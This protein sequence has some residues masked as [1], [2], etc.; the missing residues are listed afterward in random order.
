M[1]RIIYDFNTKN[2]L[3]S[4]NINAYKISSISGDDLYLQVSSNNNIKIEGNIIPTI[5]EN[6]DLG[7]SNNKIRYIYVNEVNGNVRGNLYGNALTSTKLEKKIKIGGV[8]FT[9]EHNINLPG[10][11]LTGTQDTIGKASSAGKLKNDNSYAN[12]SLKNNDINYVGLNH[13]FEGLLNNKGITKLA[14][15]IAIIKEKLNVILADKG[16]AI[17][18]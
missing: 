11:N 3:K 7:D 8:E 4:W 16:I 1:T 13:N 14:N 9:G 18:K 10:V 17:I 2:N 12:I 6:Y 15:D 5:S